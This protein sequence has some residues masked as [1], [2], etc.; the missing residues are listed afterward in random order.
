MQTEWNPPAFG[1]HDRLVAWGRE[2]KVEFGGR[3]SGFQWI[4]LLKP[5]WYSLSLAGCQS[6][7]SPVTSLLMPSTIQCLT[8][9]S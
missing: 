5:L 9:F 6:T 7:L 4:I 1:D 8:G 2:H 3:Q